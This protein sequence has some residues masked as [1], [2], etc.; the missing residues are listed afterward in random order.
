MLYETFVGEM[1][2]FMC[3]HLRERLRTEDEFGDII[4]MPKPRNKFE[5]WAVWS[6]INSLL[7]PESITQDGQATEQE[8]QDNIEIIMRDAFRV[9]NMGYPCP[10]EVVAVD[11]SG[12]LEQFLEEEDDG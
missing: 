5:S 12:Y 1:A 8:Q 6:E 3:D 2:L 10:K 4:R 7:Q 11:D 9:F